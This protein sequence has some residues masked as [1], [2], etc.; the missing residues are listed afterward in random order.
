MIGIMSQFNGLVEHCEYRPDQAAEQSRARRT[1]FAC[2]LL[3]YCRSW[4]AATLP[5]VATARMKSLRQTASLSAKRQSNVEYEGQAKCCRLSSGRLC[6]PCSFSRCGGLRRPGHIF[7]TASRRRPDSAG[8]SWAHDKALDCINAGQ[9]PCRAGR[10]MCPRQDS[11]LRSRLRRAVL[12]P[13]SYGGRSCWNDP[14]ALLGRCFTPYPQVAWS[15]VGSVRLW[16]VTC[17]FGF[18]KR[19]IPPC[20]PWCWCTGSR[21][22]PPCGVG[23]WGSWSGG[24]TSFGTTRVGLGGLGGPLG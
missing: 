1:S 18:W 24:S 7:G 21:T 20:P 23:W 4:I 5:G 11:N 17:G 12:Y 6:R 22:P 3:V 16:P 9:G 10:T 13:L 15:R 14:S 8:R 2:M 19:G